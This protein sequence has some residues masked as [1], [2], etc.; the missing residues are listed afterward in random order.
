M[1]YV[2]VPLSLADRPEL[3]TAPNSLK[4]VGVNGIYCFYFD[5]GDDFHTPGSWEIWFCLEGRSLTYVI[6]SSTRYLA[7]QWD[8]IL[9]DGPGYPLTCCRAEIH[10]FAAKNRYDED[11][12]HWQT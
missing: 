6:Y 2:P 5:E 1:E 12:L 8:M 7:S 4:E 11:A 9:V 10:W 3:A